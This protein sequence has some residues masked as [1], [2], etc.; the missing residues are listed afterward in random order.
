MYIRWNSWHEDAKGR[1]FLPEHLSG[2]DYVGCLVE[3]SNVRVFKETF[4]KGEGCWGCACSREEPCACGTAK[5]L[6]EDYE[7]CGYC[8][9]DHEYEPNESHSWHAEHPGQGY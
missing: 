2:S 7:P 8:G 4:A 1:W 6:P 5:E 3:Q 9:F